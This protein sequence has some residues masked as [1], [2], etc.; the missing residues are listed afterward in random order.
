MTLYAENLNAAYGKTDVLNDV[1]VQF[2]REKFYAL[3]GPNGSGK[4]TLLKVLAGLKTPT[5]GTIKGLS[6]VTPHAQQIAYLSQ[7]RI[8]HPL[9][10][11]SDIVALGRAPYRK[12]FGNLTS[13][14]KNS[15][16]MAI[17]KTDL[18]ALRD[19]AYGKLS[20]GQQARVLLAR[21]LAVDAPILLVDE[22]AAALDPYYQLTIL[23]LLEQEALTGKTVIAAL[24]DLALIQQF[25]DEIVV[26]KNGYIQ[27]KGQAETT[28][29]NEILASVF[30]IKKTGGKYRPV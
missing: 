8:A 2:E 17:E 23:E 14:D 22:P 7:T 15:I 11:V 12:P 19:K 20:G 29:T 25:S 28:L 5:G 30:H 10:T 1:S 27:A 6:N 26:M 16:E 13:H 3:I 21:A 4:S 9:M 18:T 24:H